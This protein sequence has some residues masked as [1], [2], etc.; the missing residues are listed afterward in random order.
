MLQQHVWAQADPQSADTLEESAFPETQYALATLDRI[1][2]T[3]RQGTSDDRKRLGGGEC[4][5]FLVDLVY[6]GIMTLMTMGQGRP[7]TLVRDRIESLKWLL[8][9]T[10]NRWLLAGK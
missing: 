8:R 9:R 10:R 2:D 4:T 5:V 3:F 7:S 1:S 6:R